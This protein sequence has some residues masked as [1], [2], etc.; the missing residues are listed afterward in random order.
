MTDHRD[1][2]RLDVLGEPLAPWQPLYAAVRRWWA[3]WHR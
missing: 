2:A 3:R 1:P